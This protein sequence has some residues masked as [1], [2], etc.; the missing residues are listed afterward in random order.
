MNMI[1]S[2][3]ILRLMNLFFI[4]IGFLVDMIIV[5]NNLFFIILIYIR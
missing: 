3:I 5:V 4:E 2:E 1:W